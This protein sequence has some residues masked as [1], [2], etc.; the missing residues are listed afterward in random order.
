[1]S[2]IRVNK[3]GALSGQAFEIVDDDGTTTRVSL[4][5]DGT[6]SVVDNI[7]INSAGTDAVGLSIGDGTPVLSITQESDKFRFQ[8]SG[9]GYGSRPIQIGRDDGDNEITIPGNL[10][11]GSDHDAA[12][13]VDCILTPASNT[14]P[15]F[16][17]LNR[18]NSTNSDNLEL[19]QYST[20]GDLST[21]AYLI[22]F[23]RENPLDTETKIG[24]VTGNGSG[25]VAFNTSFTGQH[26]TVIVSGSYQVGMIAESTGEIWIRNAE[27]ITTALP[28][29]QLSSTEKSKTVYGVVADLSGSYDGY[30]A[31]GGLAPDE[32][33]IAVN[34]I[35]EGLIL[36]TNYNGNVQNGDYIV[37][38]EISGYG[39]KQDDDLLR[40][41]TIAK[42]TEN[43]DW[44]S[45][46]ETVEHGGSSY[47]VYLA[48]CT[49]HC[50]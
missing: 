13:Q 23:I 32:M 38:S 5:T 47:K 15:A 12:Y 14:T 46:T 50:G 1:M 6:L 22:K 30:V 8:V 11:I 2:L 45:V 36:V 34:S 20:G 27:T 31:N 19:T 42:C 17:I 21:S 18:Y 24:S 26:A 49:Y 48:A 9:T 44:S 41:S 29:V 40:S 39:M 43:I 33:H 25:G 4:A 10:A 3:I 37:S 7:T 28:K 16:R 35:G